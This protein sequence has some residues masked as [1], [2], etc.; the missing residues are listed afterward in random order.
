MDDS[1]LVVR[2]PEAHLNL[3]SGYFTRQVRSQVR[4][5]AMELHRRGRTLVSAFDALDEHTNIRILTA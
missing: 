3:A 1:A 4:W 5:L 2:E